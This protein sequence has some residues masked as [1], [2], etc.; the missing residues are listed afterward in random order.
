M[1]RLAEPQKTDA[2]ARRAEFISLYSLGVGRIIPPGNF[3]VR[4]HGG[5]VVASLVTGNTVVL[6]PAGTRRPLPRNSCHFV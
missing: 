5:A 3:P 2:D 4:H 6:K 1:L